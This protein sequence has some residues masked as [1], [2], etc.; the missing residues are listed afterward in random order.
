[1]HS[2]CSDGQLT[3]QQ[4]VAL[5]AER[6]CEQIAITDHDSI[7][8]YEQLSDQTTPVKVIAGCEFSTNWRGREIHVVGLNLDLHN[9]VLLDGIEHQQRARRVRAERIGESDDDASSCRGRH[10]QRGRARSGGRICREEDVSDHHHR[11]C[12]RLRKRDGWYGKE[13]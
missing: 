13:D 8:A 5:A 12:P 9:P 2:R 1:M 6:G 7:A 10:R 11:R 4:L 3:P